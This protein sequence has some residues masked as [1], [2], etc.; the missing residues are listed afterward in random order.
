MLVAEGYRSS[1]A[2]SELEGWLPHPT[3][4]YM[5]DVDEDMEEKQK[6]SSSPSKEPDQKRQ[7]LSEE[8]EDEKLTFRKGDAVIVSGLGKA[9][10]YN[11]CKGTVKSVNADTGRVA[12]RIP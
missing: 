6:E 2:P 7:K 8:A 5:P 11:G 1:S 10:Q 9:P 3:V 4:I 12:V